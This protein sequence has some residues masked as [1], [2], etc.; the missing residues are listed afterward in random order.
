VKSV[1]AMQP[2]QQVQA[3]V[4]KLKE[5]NP[6]FDG[7]ETHKIEGGAVTVLSFSTVGVTDISPVKALRWLRTLSIAPP[8]LNQK[9]SL[10]NLAPLQGM[11]LTLLWC[12][13]NP[14]TDLSPLKG[15]PLTTL[16]FGGTQVTELSPL[17][18]MKLQVLS[19]ND[20]VVSDIAPLEGM[21][22]TVLWCNNTKVADLTP[23]KAMP[24]RELKCD[25]V[26]ERDASVLRGIRT[27]AKINDMPVATFWMRVGPVMAAAPP[28]RNVGGGSAPRPGASTPPHGRGS[29]V[30]PTSANTSG[31]TISAKE[32]IRRFAEKMKELNPDWD[33]QL[34]HKLE[35]GK[36]VEVC[37][38][39]SAVTDISP[40]RE[41]GGLRVLACNGPVNSTGYPTL[42]SGK[43]TS[44]SALQGLPLQELDCRNNPEIPDLQP[45]KGMRLRT[46]R[47]GWTKIGDL[48][49]IAGMPLK[50]LDCRAT[51][52][53][54]LSP[55]KGMPLVE[56]R[57]ED[58]PVADLT[59]LKGLPL[60]VLDCTCK[61]I[62]DLS[63]IK[64][65]R[66]DFLYCGRSQVSDI[67]SVKGMPLTRLFIANSLVRDI[68]AI[69]GME[70]KTLWC[71]RTQ[72]TDLTPLKGMPLT[73]LAFDFVPERD[74]KIVRSVKTLSRINGVSAAEFWKRV[75]A[76]E[77][78]QPQMK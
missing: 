2:E 57:L 52:V 63:P 4:A 43:L 50:V 62:K 78:P 72:V 49:T 69:K 15:M 54:D 41:I 68:S 44:L 7:K 6:N 31:G 27:L 11:Q 47:C 3:V 55:L 70:L 58:A 28:V 65:M 1:S 21:P 59:P 35:A 77:S 60:K 16:S 9:G 33:G 42:P 13:N 26:P 5:L 48:S 67:S 20:T 10:E 75:D 19:F 34:E 45:L 14:I 36:I 23:L 61:Q 37:F 56:L 40:V 76:G 25:F 66:L 18:G 32:Q 46:L 39:T 12:H 17:T 8:A 38:T 71:Y 74:T 29:E 53:G 22:L 73:D 30:G 51:Q 24:L 64:G